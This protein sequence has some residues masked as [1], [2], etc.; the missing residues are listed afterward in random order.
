MSEAVVNNDVVTG[1]DYV[2]K[3]IHLGG[4]LLAVTAVTGIILGVV[5]HFTSAAIRQVELAAKNEAFKN[6][7]PIAQTFEPMDK[8]ESDYVLDIVQAKDASG[9]VGWCMTVETKSYGGPLQF[10]AGITKDGAVKAINIL[11]HSDTPGLGARA[12]EP[13]FYG[14]FTDKSQLPLKVVKGSAGNPDEIAAISGA[15]ITSNAVVDGVNA[16]VEYW[17][18]NLK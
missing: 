12:T 2:K 4:T 9:V 6:V 14:Q 11:S 15:T 17:S 18:K 10:I 3:A 5:E 13:E 16:A 7:M 8:A 1:K